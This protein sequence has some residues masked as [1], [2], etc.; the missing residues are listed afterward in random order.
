[1]MD[2]PAETRRDILA[3]LAIIA[4]L[5]AVFAGRPVWRRLFYRAPAHDRCA[6]LL[7]RYAELSAR[8]YE[9][10]PRPA[11]G[12]PYLARDVDGCVRSLT[13]DEVDCALRAGYVDELERC[14]PP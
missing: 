7:D 3:T 12:L 14:L 5:A 11:A 2:G 13:E 8:S 10:V 4:L 6:A 9:R 1:M